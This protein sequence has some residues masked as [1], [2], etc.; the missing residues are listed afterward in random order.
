[1]HIYAQRYEIEKIGFY[2]TKKKSGLGVTFDNIV[3]QTLSELQIGPKTL[4]VRFGGIIGVGK[5]LLWLIIFCA[6]SVL[7]F[8]SFVNGKIKFNT[9]IRRR[10]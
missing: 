7:G 8:W 1:M 9:R 10:I 2:A 5:N 4:L 6:S 3:E